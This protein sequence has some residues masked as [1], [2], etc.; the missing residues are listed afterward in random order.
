MPT[1]LK[2]ELN[3]T[4]ASGAAAVTREIVVVLGGAVARGPIRAHTCSI[5]TEVGAGSWHK[6]VSDQVL[7]S[8]TIIIFERVPFALALLDPNF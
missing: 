2:N 4:H 5:T 8:K 3:C 7:R 1:G 6:F